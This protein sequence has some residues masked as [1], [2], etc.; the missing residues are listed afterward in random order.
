[1]RS[2]QCR[3]SWMP[4]LLLLALLLLWGMTACHASDQPDLPSTPSQDDPSSNDPSEG[5]IPTEQ[6]DANAATSLSER[7]IEVVKGSAIH[8]NVYGRAPYGL[9]EVVNGH[10]AVYGP[11]LLDGTVNTFQTQTN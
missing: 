2:N 11:L 8:E 4:L 9:T 1:M 7:E 3:L 10:M 6:P 5:D